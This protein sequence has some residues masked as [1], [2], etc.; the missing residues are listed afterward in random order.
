[1]PE[2][3]CKEK[4]PLRKERR[5][6]KEPGE[7]KE[8]EVMEQR[9][10]KGILALG[11]LV[12]VFLLELGLAQEQVRLKEV[13]VTAT[14]TEVPVEELG[15]SATIITSE[16]IRDRQVTD[17]LELLRDVAGLTMV[18]SGSRGALA[19]LYFRGT[20]SNHTLVLIDGVKVNEAGGG[21]DWSTITT[22]NVERIEIIRGPQSALYGSEA[23][24]GVIHIITKK[25]QGP[26]KIT[27]STAHGGHS[28]NG[29]YMGEQKLSLSGGSQWAGYSLAFSR[30]DDL[31][32]LS[33]NNDY[34]N[35]TLSGR[36]D[37][38]PT[39]KLDVT[40]TARFTN[41]RFGI[42]TE[43]GGDI[44]DRI[45][46]GLDPD[47]YQEK[48]DMV[49]SIGAKLQLF[50]WWEHVIQAGLHRLDQKFR[51]RPD[52]ETAF[53]FPPGSRTDSLETRATLDYHTN[54]KFPAQGP[55]RSTLTLGYQFDHEALDLDAFSTFRFGPPPFGIFTSSERREASRSN[56]GYYLQEQVTILDRLHLTGGFRVED[57]SSYGMEV[58]PRGSVAYEL[59]ETGTK[60]RGAAGTG[61]K[62]PTFLENFGG[63]GTIGN[64]DLKPERI[65][66]WEIGVD[67]YLLDRKVELG[68][69]Y[70]RNYLKDLITYVPTSWPPPPV[71]PPNYF[72]IQEAEDW[73]VELGVK[74]RPFSGL[75][76]GGT[77]T[78][79][80][81]EVTN[82][83]GL[84]NLYFA[85]GKK[86]LR[87][88]NHTGSFFVNWAWKGLNVNLRSSYVGPRDDT[89]FTVSPGP[90]GFY[91]FVNRRVT[92]QDYFVVD[93]ALS[94]TLDLSSGPVR[95]VRFFA[96]GRNILNEKY[97]EV[98]GYSSPRASA[99]GGVEFSF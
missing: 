43:N 41:N 33:K 27:F 83:G 2:E 26:P 91:D 32:I 6:K 92:N 95:S 17:V 34:W 30:I 79:L 62:E 35:N 14:R 31:G 8:G 16:E 98:Y 85:K 23:M 57:N 37:L 61:I 88:P 45:F 28:E 99:I 71:L 68:V 96:K 24:G 9:A 87:R 60:F 49:G 51:D 81:T 5:G 89:F 82:D 18:Q 50:P 13:V 40:M 90:F 21:F 59:K 39:E 74:I 46:P 19:Q 7:G 80:D 44:P 22:D 86:L 75:T 53:D 77:Y 10:R 97:E 52:A 36:L 54:F 47:Q 73:G 72:N 20:E 69:T 38:Y 11:A 25:G 78:F 66:S 3:R 58:N 84:G 4:A 93:L 64:P 42:A 15:V 29:K 63:F 48:I 56:H 65:F 1:M 12:G 76:V 55:V 94:Y 70:F 67:Q